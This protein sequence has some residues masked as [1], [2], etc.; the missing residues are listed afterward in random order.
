MRPDPDQARAWL[1][2]ELSKP[3]YHQQSLV[4]RL[5]DWLGGLWDRLTALASNADELS[6]SVALA[7]ALAALVLALLV[8]PRVRRT[9]KAPAGDR[10]VLRAGR[11]TADEHLARAQTALAESR[12]SD[13][14]VEAMRAL[15]RSMVDRG[16]LEETPGS[17]AHEIAV[18]LADAFPE[19]RER[20]QDAALLFDAV[21][22]G[23][24]GASRDQATSLLALHDELRSARPGAAGHSA[25]GVAVAPR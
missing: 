14:V 5:L 21:Q 11:V 19:H 22:Y 20:L 7:L 13:A 16:I 18:A 24:A 9:P 3:E 2:S 10:A 12:Y 23:G 8:V 17:T 15:A 1:E 6:T 4:E 25:P